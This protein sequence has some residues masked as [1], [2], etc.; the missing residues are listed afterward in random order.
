MLIKNII[1]QRTQEEKIYNYFMQ[2]NAMAHT[3]NMIAS[4]KVH[5]KQSQISKS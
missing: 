2:D 3:A 4:E 1:L 5:K